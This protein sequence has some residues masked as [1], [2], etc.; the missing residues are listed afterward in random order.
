MNLA[1]FIISHRLWWQQCM[2]GG[3][4]RRVERTHV[5]GQ[6]AGPVRCWQMTVMTDGGAIPCIRGGRAAVRPTLHRRPPTGHW[7]MH[8]IGLLC[9][10]LASWFFAVMQ[11]TL[12]RLQSPVF[13]LYALARP[14]PP[15]NPFRSPL[16]AAARRWR[17]LAPARGLNPA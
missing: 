2:T 15:P 10:C 1:I 16:L 7:P 9:F 8:C 17:A 6:L 12:D 3:R 4:Y 13:A 5:I 11:A 14:A